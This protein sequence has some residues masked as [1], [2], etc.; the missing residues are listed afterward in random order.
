M[1]H[2]VAELARSMERGMKNKQRFALFSRRY[3]VPEDTCLSSDSPSKIVIVRLSVYEIAGLI[4]E[5]DLN[6]T[7]H[8]YGF[9]ERSGA[10]ENYP[11]EWQHGRIRRKHPRKLHRHPIIIRRH[12]FIFDSVYN[13]PDSFYLQW[14]AKA[15]K[16]MKC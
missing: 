1:M 4:M 16:A 6:M 12:A 15:I 14:S 3:E 9:S 7:E 10:K 8:M 13:A 11:A 2:Y 5:N